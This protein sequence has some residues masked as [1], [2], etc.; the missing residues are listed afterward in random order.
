MIG[1]DYFYKPSIKENVVYG[2]F[3]HKVELVDTRPWDQR[4]LVE[5]FTAVMDDLIRRQKRERRNDS[6]LVWLPRGKH[7]E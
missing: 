6:N 1:E 2:T 3:S 5:D 7:K 4:A